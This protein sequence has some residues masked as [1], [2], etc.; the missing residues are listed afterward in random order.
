MTPFR[1]WLPSSRGMFRDLNEFLRGVVEGDSRLTEWAPTIDVIEDASGY[2][3]KAEVPGMK[4]ADIE[5]TLSGDTLTIRG[6]KHREEKASDTNW[7]MLERFAGNFQ[8]SFRFPAAMRPDSVDATLSDGV[9]TVR[10]QKASESKPAQIKV[11]G[12]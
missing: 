7:L 12:K 6:E 9:L 4:P 8:R 5:V 1:S 3:L 2:L 11:V 10:V